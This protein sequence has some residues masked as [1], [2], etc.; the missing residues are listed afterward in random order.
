VPL[1]PE[2]ASLALALVLFLLI[3]ALAAFLPVPHAYPP[4]FCHPASTRG[5]A[6]THTYAG[7]YV[8]HRARSV[9]ALQ[10]LAASISPSSPSAL[11][12]SETHQQQQQ[13]PDV[14]PAL[15]AFMCRNRRRR[16]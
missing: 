1:A 9:S 14:H 3:H 15:S 7:A 8:M 16:L 10:Y 11:K 12:L 13:Q 5:Y 4:S 2:A 6:H